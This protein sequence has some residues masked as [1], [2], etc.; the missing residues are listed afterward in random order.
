MQNTWEMICQVE[1]DSLLQIGH[2][3]KS[4][5]KMRMQINAPSVDL[6][7]LKHL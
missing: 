5:W 6:D 7:I 4:L 1:F 2:W 3:G